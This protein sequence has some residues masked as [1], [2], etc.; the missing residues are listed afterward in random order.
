MIASMVSPT[1]TKRR[2]RLTAK[3]L[4]VFLDLILA[5]LAL[6]FSWWLRYE[7]EIGPDLTEFQHLEFRYYQPVLIAHIA[8][9]FVAFQIARVYRLRRSTGLVQE[10]GRIFLGSTLA[11]FFI[12]AVFFLYRPEGYAGYSRGMFIFLWLNT[13]LIISAS[14]LLTRVG[15]DALRRRGRLLEQLVVVGGGMH[16]K[17]IMQQVVTH[18]NMGYRLVGFLR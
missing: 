14:R 1:K 3:L 10:I 2:H 5:G 8:L 4:V 17:M 18:Q 13:P 6:Y 15:V 9:V 16:G 11:A 7:M 12:I